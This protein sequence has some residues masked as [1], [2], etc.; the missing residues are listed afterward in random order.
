MSSFPDVRVLLAEVNRMEVC[1]ILFVQK[2][3]IIGI[4]KEVTVPVVGLANCRVHT[5][6]GGVNK[7]PERDVGVGIESFKI[8]CKHFRHETKSQRCRVCTYQSCSGF[9][10]WHTRLPLR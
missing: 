7:N 3:A 1:P 8:I 5:S 6:V 10:I 4:A 9:P 2:S